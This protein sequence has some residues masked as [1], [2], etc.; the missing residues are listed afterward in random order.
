MPGIEIK[1]SRCAM[2][3]LILNADDFGMTRGINEGIVRAHQEGIL[4]STTLMATGAA[5]DDAVAKVK[6]TPTLGVGCHVVLVGSV[7]VTPREKI[8]S[9]ADATGQLPKSLPTL[10][11]KVTSG[12]VRIQEIELE[13]RAQI[14]KIRSA[15]IEPTH[16]D[17]HKHTH[18]H[19]RVMHA[20]GRV[21]RELKIHCVRKP[22]E[23][24]WDSWNSSQRASR[25]F[26]QLA[27]AAAVRAISVTF[28]SIA[29]QY[30]LRS[31]D[32]FLGLSATG[33]LSTETLS[34]LIERSRVGTTEIMLHPGVPDAELRSTGDRLQEHRQREL[35]ALLSAGSKLAV[36]KHGIDLITYR[37]L[38]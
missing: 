22:V 11:A 20:L 6:V 35:E 4:T 14:E 31:P 9:L 17:T 34:R 37:E 3:R 36:A 23:S 25:S 29:H 1:G 21:A 33:Q 38:D 32:Y 26:S 28:D 5:F 19:P 8:P 16:L 30:G 10:V 27:A 13:I 7:A 15:G 12:A 2:K 18:A 24:L